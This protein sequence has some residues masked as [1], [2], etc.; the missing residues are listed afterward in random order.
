MAK[1]FNT[2]SGLV[3]QVELIC[4]RAVKNVT[5][6]LV[7]KLKEYIQEDF[8]DLY[9]SRIYRR[10]YQFLQSPAYNMIGNAKA[11]IFIDTDSMEYFDITGEDVARLAMEGFHGSEDIFRPGY[12]WKD[13]E[14][15]CNDN[16]LILLRGELIKQGLNIK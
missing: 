5:L 2:V 3:K 11:E 1:S 13:F 15:W 12:Y 7:E 10:T 16:V 8:Y 9:Y 14:N 4:D 6:I